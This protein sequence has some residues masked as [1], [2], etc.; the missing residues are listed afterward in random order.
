MRSTVTPK[1]IM[2]IVALS[3]INT[4]AVSMPVL[5]AGNALQDAWIAT[6]LGTLGGILVAGIA[7]TLASRFPGRT[8]GEFSKDILGRAL[9]T[10]AGLVLG[11]FFF[12]VALL[13]SRQLVL[14]FITTTLERTPDW[15]IAIPILILGVYGAILGSDTIGR[16]APVLLVMVVAAMGFGVALLSFS[17]EVDLLEITPILAQGISPALVASINPI[18]WFA[19]SASVSLVMTGLSTKPDRVRHAVTMGILI[20][21]FV[22]TFL[23]AMAVATLGA[24]EAS[25]QLSPLLTVS[26]TVFLAN[27]TER[28]DVLLF[29]LWVPGISFDL[30]LFLFAASFTLSKALGVSQI[31]LAVTLGTLAILFAS[32]GYAD[33]F[34]VRENLSILTTGMAT[35]TIHI[36]LVGLVLAVAAIRGKHGRAK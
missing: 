3:R 2:A 20:S 1:Q 35:L 14:L 34:R 5:T 16:A 23:V 13:R 25:V 24:A 27:V 8:F 12:A 7:T 19:T 30:A 33:M 6:F 29:A 21:G 4:M 10:T 28:L 17:V 32:L 31:T 26:R 22:V 18:F 9:G 15:A 36:G 11:A